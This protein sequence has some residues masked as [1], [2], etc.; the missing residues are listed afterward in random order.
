MGEVRHLG[1]GQ[2]ASGRPSRIPS[3]AGVPSNTPAQGTD[4][5]QVFRE[6]LGDHL[7]RWCGRLSLTPADLPNPDF[8]A[9]VNCLHSLPLSQSEEEGT[10]AEKVALTLPLLMAGHLIGGPFQLAT[11]HAIQH[12]YGVCDCRGEGENIS[13][14]HMPLPYVLCTT[15]LAV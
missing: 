11:P 15:S 3:P 14:G 6:M 13:S 2:P 10:E 12:C 1:Q 7:S 5:L 9:R 8:P 4:S